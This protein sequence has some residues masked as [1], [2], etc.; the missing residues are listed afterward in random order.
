MKGILIAH[1]INGTDLRRMGV[2]EVLDLLE[3]FATIGLV[4]D[5]DYQ[6]GQHSRLSLYGTVSQAWGQY[7]DAM[8]HTS[9]YPEIER[10][11]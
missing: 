8:G 3:F 5:Q 4:S 9:L 11:Q 7:R 2:G 6:A 1:G 10:D